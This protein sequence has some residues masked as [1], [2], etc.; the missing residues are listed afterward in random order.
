[1]QNWER[2][3]VFNWYRLSRKEMW[4]AADNNND[5]YHTYGKGFLD[6]SF[7]QAIITKISNFHENYPKF[8][9]LTKIII[10]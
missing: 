6:L 7:N 1:M 4:C 3:S 2:K 8:Y 5:M 9:I 10:F